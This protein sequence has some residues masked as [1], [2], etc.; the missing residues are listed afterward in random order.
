MAAGIQFVN[1]ATLPVTFKFII[2]YCTL[3]QDIKSKDFINKTKHSLP[4]CMLLI[5]I[6]QRSCHPS[7]TGTANPDACLSGVHLSISAPQRFILSFPYNISCNS[8]FQYSFRKR[9]LAVILKNSTLLESPVYFHSN[10]RICL[11]SWYFFVTSC[12]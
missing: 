5:H 8:L 2:A 1:S 11:I 6:F 7:H 10:D 9:L 4:Q 12:Y 3:Q